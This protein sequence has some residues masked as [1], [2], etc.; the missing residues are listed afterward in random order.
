MKKINFG[1]QKSNRTRRPEGDK[2]LLC[3][4]LMTLKT[5]YGKIFLEIIVH[6][7]IQKVLASIVKQIEVCLEM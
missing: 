4:M 3:E 2:F 7:N 5:R 6:V 1:W